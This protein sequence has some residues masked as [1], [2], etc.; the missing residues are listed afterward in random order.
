MV[1]SD[2][3]FVAFITG[4]DELVGQTV[5]REQIVLLDRESGQFT[6]VSRN[7]ADLANGECIS[8]RNQRRRSLC[9][10]HFPSPPTLVRSTRPLAVCISLRP[11]RPGLLTLVSKATD[12]NGPNR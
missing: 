5:T 1:S 10:I 11:K 7:G 9:R 6:T 12:G 3:R 4:A 8:L 2:G